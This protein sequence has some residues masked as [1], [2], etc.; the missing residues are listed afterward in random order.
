MQVVWYKRDLRLRDH[1]PLAAAA[2]AGPVLCLYV[3]EPELLQSEEFD[4]AHFDFI[5]ECLAELDANLR[6]HGAW[7]T[8]RTGRMPDV[9]DALHAHTPI[10][11][12]HSHEET[13]NQITYDRDRR[14]GA[15]ARQQQVPWHEYP[16]TGVIRR[17][18]TRDGWAARWARRMREAQAPL[19]ARLTPVTGIDVAARPAAS[20][21]GVK[22]VQR[23]ERM[24][25]G[26]AQ[27]HEV[28]ETF[29]D[30]RGVN[31]RKDMS[32]PVAG[33]EGCSRL[34]PY[35]AWG[36][37]S[38]K[39]VYQATRARKDAMRAL[40]QN[41]GEV[42]RRWFGSLQSF[43]ARLRWHC[44]FTQ[45]LEDEPRLEFENL[46]R[47]YD[48]LREDAFDED[49]FDAYCAGQT[50]YPMVDACIRA[51]QAGGWINFRMRAMLVSFS[52]Y[53]LWL[54]WRRPGLF[55]GRLFL[56]FEPGIHWSQTQMQ[57]GTTGI[58]TVRIYSPRKQVLDQDPDGLFV[59]KYVP[60][61]AAFPNA[62]LAE[63]H[64]DPREQQARAGCVIGR[65]YPAPIVDHAT[66]YK[67]AR[68]RVYRVRRTAEARAE[69]QRVVK[70]H[71]SRK[72]PAR[73]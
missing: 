70:K 73:R 62:F 48:G 20:A 30:H 12:L 10:H 65:D 28:L 61:L 35:L 44:H 26:E 25:G 42:D 63:P 18:K 4:Q 14:V 9:L 27:A 23:P 40:E 52:S 13:G 31:Y 36:A 54:H 47:V 55:L 24:R 8:T 11:A 69:A 49:R 33:W 16:Q 37:I 6:R 17:L 41:G 39:Q 38:I 22:A 7:L 29:L 53:H 67:E 45:K 64:L 56:D 50:G 66:A 71:G 3:Y 2:Q 21:L 72:S 34:S 59:R 32:S 15:W 60:E 57:S 58:N 1:A 19:P 5:E 68:D 43:E 51:L 46:A